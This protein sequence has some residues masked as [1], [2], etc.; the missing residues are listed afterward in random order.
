MCLPEYFPQ[1]PVPLKSPFIITSDKCIS[2]GD[3][4][5]LVEQADR[6]LA[7]YL[8][9]YNTLA[10]WG[11]NVLDTIVQLWAAWGR[12]MTTVV[13]D[14]QL[15]IARIRQRLALW[16]EGVMITT[17][18]RASEIPPEWTVLTLPLQSKNSIIQPK[19][20]VNRRPGTI[21]FTSG[22]SGEPKGVYHHLSQHWY[23]AL[24][25][26]RNLTL[27]P[28]D[29]WMLVLP[30]HHI[31]G[32]AIMFRVFLAGA[33]LVLPSDRRSFWEE[34]D[35]LGI[36]HISLV[37]TQLRRWLNEASSPPR[38]L[39]A[40][41]VG[42][43]PV[44]QELISEAYTRGWPLYSTYGC[45][46]MGSQVCTTPPGAPLEQLLTS[47]QLLPY[48]QLKI[49][50]DG[51]ILVRGT[52]RFTGYLTPQGWL[53]PF[54]QAGWYNTGDLGFID[55]EGFLHVTGRRD[56][57]FKAGGEWVQPE[58]VERIIRK[59]PSVA[60]V[61]VVKQIDR[62]FQHRPVAFIAWK[63]KPPAEGDFKNWLKLHLARYEQPAALYAMP[64]IKQGMK[65][66]RKA[67]EDYLQQPDSS[68]LERLP[69]GDRN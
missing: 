59:H 33:A 20:S 29:R 4:A 37:T 41:L 39:R 69:F 17:E 30:L 53:H 46:E 5:R 38:A 52:V 57:R 67:F 12:G 48:R 2:Y 34:V 63:G 11:L 3:F 56:L 49:S 14:P 9:G 40:V 43:G 19:R 54:D 32:L 22:T 25:A 61:L 8:A 27:G 36:T 7:P 47:G 24:G 31:G 16:P 60:E 1:P 58:L 6:A 42:G 65:L 50:P 51:E 45:T 26:N 18:N 10:C 15:P 68:G 13:L 35:D 28:G 21:V 55:E 62:E 66:S 44:D 23:Q 64:P